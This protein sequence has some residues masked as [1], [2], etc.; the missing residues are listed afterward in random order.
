MNLSLCHLFLI[1]AKYK[2]VI[3][4]LKALQYYQKSAPREAKIL[5]PKRVKEGFVSVYG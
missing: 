5:P 2:N 3:R 1:Q 4:Y